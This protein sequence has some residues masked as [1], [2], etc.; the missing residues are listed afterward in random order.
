VTGAL[1]VTIE[2][3]RSSARLRGGGWRL[4]LASGMSA[5]WSY[6]NTDRRLSDRKLCAGGVLD[7]NIHFI[8][9]YAR[10]FEAATQLQY[11]AGR[12]AHLDRL[13]EFGPKPAGHQIVRAERRQEQG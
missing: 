7:P 1:R 6:A 11:R 8:A 4:P 2:T 13:D 9:D 5:F 12:Q 3:A 10:R